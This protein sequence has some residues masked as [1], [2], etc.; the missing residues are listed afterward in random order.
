[1]FELNL[2][3]LIPGAAVALDLLWGDPHWLP[4][5]VR[6]IGVLAKRVEAYGRFQAEGNPERA[7]G[8]WAV[9]GLVAAVILPL[10]FLTALPLVG[11]FIAVY[12]GYSGLAL[13]CLLGEAA[14][15]AKSIDAGKLDEARAGLAML[16]TRDTSAMDADKLRAGLAETVSENFNDGFVAPF[17]YL[18]LLGPL[19]LWTYKTISTLDSMWGYRTE[20][21]RD[22]GWF[23][24]RTDDVLAWVPARLS[25]GL[26]ILVGGIMGFDWKGALCHGPADARKMESPNAGWPMAASAWL[27]GRSMG[28]PAVYHGK[29]KEKPMLGPNGRTWDAE[30]LQDLLGLVS[31]TGIGTALAGQIIILLVHSL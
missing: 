27:I 1:M 20:E 25:A 22:L 12:F 19:G 24:A 17:F 26:L 2:S 3:C 31:V 23:A 15:V 18:C 14:D 7:F 6:G 28:G 10:W 16:V 11:I 5:P 13:R 9:C 29:A 30:S 21:Y 4:H 8:F